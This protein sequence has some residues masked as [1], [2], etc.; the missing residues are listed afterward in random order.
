MGADYIGKTAQ[1]YGIHY[2]GRA[3]NIEEEFGTAQ[4]RDAA[5]LTDDQP[6]RNLL[7]GGHFHIDKDGCFIPP[8]CTG[9]R[10][11]LGELVEGIPEGAYPVFEA[12]YRR[13]LAGLLALAR[14]RGFNEDGRGYVSKCALCFHLRRGLAEQGFAELDADYY[15]ESLSYYD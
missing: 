7:A 9:L 14:E 5:A 1:V 2:G 13:G 4:R 10:L 12:L 6:C 15:R 11:P 8:G 3:I